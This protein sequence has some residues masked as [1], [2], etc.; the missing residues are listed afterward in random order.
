MLYEVITR[1]AVSAAAA[2]LVALVVGL[3]AATYGLIEARRANER[4]RQ[5]AAT[6]DKVSEFL[7]ELF[8]VS[9]PSEARGNTITAREVLDRGVEQIDSGF[10]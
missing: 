9:D 7:V 5:E 4:T 10:V 3:G 6:A 8:E 2:V 1:I